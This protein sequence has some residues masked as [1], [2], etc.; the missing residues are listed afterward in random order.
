MITYAQN[1]EDVKLARVFKDRCDGF[2]VDVGAGDPVHLN[3]T[4]WFYDLGWNG[5]NIEPNRALYQRLV[6]ER[7]RDIN[8]AVGA[9]A[10]RGEAQFYELAIDEL[11]SFDPRVCKSA[12]EPGMLGETRI[13]PVLPLNEILATHGDGRHVDFLKIDVEGWEREVLNG[14]DLQRYRPTVLVVE[15]TF[16]GTR[17]ESYSEWEGILNDSAFSFVHFDGLNR[18]YVAKENIDLKR[19]FALPPN[20]FDEIKNAQ[21]VA[22]ETEVQRLGAAMESMQ[23]ELVATEAEVR[24]LGAAL[25][26]KQAELVATEAEVRRLD[27]TTETKQAE[28]DS[29]GERLAQIQQSTATLWGRLEHL[30]VAINRGGARSSLQSER[31]DTYEGAMQVIGE[32]VLVLRSRKATLHHF[33]ALNAAKLWSRAS[34]RSRIF[35]LL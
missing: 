13:V 17:V 8:L 15:A 32:A 6:T 14:L 27:A 5:I 21:L 20:I 1:F 26:S 19:H 34:R 3:V 2:Y 18:F 7:P 31:I 23:A 33:F 16:P 22:T 24:R 12:A 9:G 28:L 29:L 11:S 30:A 35:A 4:K 10:V 25:E